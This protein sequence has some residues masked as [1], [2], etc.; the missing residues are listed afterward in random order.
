MRRALA[1]TARDVW[2]RWRGS[3]GGSEADR[4]GK[5]SWR[6]R[7]SRKHVVTIMLPVGSCGRANA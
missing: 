1:L 3:R 6:M 4:V 7:P 2:Q 5:L